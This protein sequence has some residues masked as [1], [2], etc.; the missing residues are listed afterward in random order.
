MTGQRNVI[1]VMETV[2]TRPLARHV[3]TIV[4]ARFHLAQRSA[5]ED[6]AVWIGVG[7]Y[8]AHV[9]LHACLPRRTPLRNH[10]MIARK[11]RCCSLT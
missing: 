5:A 11:L 1:A 9:T 10:P 6:V 7:G 3:A 4:P 8:L 2:M